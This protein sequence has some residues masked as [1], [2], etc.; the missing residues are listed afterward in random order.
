MK[1]ILLLIFFCSAISLSS[2]TIYKVKIRK[3]IKE[4]CSASILGKSGG[5]IST[6]ELRTV[7]QIET[8]GP[9]DYQIISYVFSFV[10]RQ[11][12]I[13]WK[14]TEKKVNPS[15]KNALRSFK[16]GEKFW[17]EKIIVKNNVTGRYF[18][19]PPLK[20]IVTL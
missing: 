8:S 4:K 13:E 2:Q 14:S 15:I 12:L 18:T 17:V 1:Q 7:N 19:M 10:V 20:F 5:K 3:P 11:M 16:P 6:Y 9:C